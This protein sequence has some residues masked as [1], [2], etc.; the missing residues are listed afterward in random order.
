M[1]YPR[2]PYDHYIDNETALRCWHRRLIASSEA[3]KSEEK[4]VRSRKLTNYKFIIIIKDL[5]MRKAIIFIYD[6]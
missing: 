6:S 1:K 2:H 5:T 4:N 3:L